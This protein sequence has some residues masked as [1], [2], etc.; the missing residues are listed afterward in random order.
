LV[1][2]ESFLV[3]LFFPKKSHFQVINWLFW[4]FFSDSLIVKIFHFPTNPYS[5]LR[6][7]PSGHKNR[8]LLVWYIDSP[9]PLTSP[10][11][12]KTLK[13]ANWVLSRWQAKEKKG[14][15]NFCH[16]LDFMP[17]DIWYFVPILFLNYDTSYLGLGQVR[18]CSWGDFSLFHLIDNLFFH[19][20]WFNLR[21]I[22]RNYM[23]DH[24][25]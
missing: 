25:T 20:W 3:L 2:E 6:S 19:F 22:L 14:N 16:W 5:T 23:K 9:L 7:Q 24:H 17:I 8:S 11:P 13:Q 4:G 18:C 21:W 1:N 10:L 15:Y 12:P